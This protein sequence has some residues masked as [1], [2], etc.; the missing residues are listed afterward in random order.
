MN[1]GG[2]ELVR[3]EM[4]ELGVLRVMQPLKFEIMKV[5]AEQIK[6]LDLSA[7]ESWQNRLTELTTALKTVTNNKKEFSRISKLI[8]EHNKKGS[9][10]REIKMQRQL[11][12]EA[13]NTGLIMFMTDEKNI[14]KILSAVYS[15]DVE[16]IDFE[17]N[18]FQCMQLAKEGLEDFF[19]Q[20]LGNTKS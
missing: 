8:E 1:I 13:D 5:Q 20:K 12:E 11:K 17:K 4:S 2:V 9:E 3:K 7:Y 16:S 10:D 6:D 19:A 15:G 18:G 14:K